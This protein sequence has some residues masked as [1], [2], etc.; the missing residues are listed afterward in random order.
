MLMSEPRQVRTHLG[1]AQFSERLLLV[2][3]FA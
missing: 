1:C 2:M 3:D